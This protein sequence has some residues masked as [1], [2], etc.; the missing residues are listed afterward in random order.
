V[1]HSSDYGENLKASSLHTSLIKQTVEMLEMGIHM[2]SC[3][4][5][6][7]V[8]IQAMKFFY[9]NKVNLKAETP[10]SSK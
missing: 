1:R 2:H 8:P 10:V 5:Y 4:V 9:G 7:K 3:H 6:R